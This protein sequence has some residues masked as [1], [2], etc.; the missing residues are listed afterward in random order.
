MNHGGNVWQGASPKQ[1]L[2]YSANIRPEGAPEWVRHALTGAMDALSYYPDPS[3]TRARRALAHF[4][5]LPEAC[6]LPTAGGISAI[7]L[8]SHLDAECA[9]QFTPCFSEYSMV[10]GNRN[11]P[12]HSVSLLTGRR[13]IGDPAALIE[14]S[15]PEKCMI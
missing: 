1:W 4:L 3:M 11:L 12:V 14:H 7:S 10:C 9:L 13:E 6:V 5:H 15:L 8:A 2:D